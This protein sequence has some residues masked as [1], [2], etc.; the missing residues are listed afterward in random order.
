MITSRNK[1]KSGKWFIYQVSHHCG[2][3]DFCLPAAIKCQYLL[4]QGSDFMSIYRLPFWN[5][6]QL[7]LEYILCMAIIVFISPYVDFPS[8]TWKTFLEAIHPF[9]YNLSASHP[10]SLQIIEPRGEGC[11]V[12]ILFCIPEFFYSLHIVQLADVCAE[13]H[14]LQEV[15][16]L[17]LERCT[18]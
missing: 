16:L 9:F 11:N 1:I 15:F 6:T 3:I 2:K 18:H 14:L 5:F 12:D 7:E 17:K 4:R 10:C 13:G 8:F